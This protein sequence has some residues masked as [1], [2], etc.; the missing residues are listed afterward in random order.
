MNALVLDGEGKFVADH[1]DT[2]PAEP[3]YRTGDTVEIRA[4]ERR[5]VTINGKPVGEPLD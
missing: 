5:Y 3:T 4:L 1:P 2:R